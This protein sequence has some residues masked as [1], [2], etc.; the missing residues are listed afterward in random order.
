MGEEML[1][2]KI[3]EILTKDL[4]NKKKKEETKMRGTIKQT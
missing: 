1:S 3:L 4:P 2:E